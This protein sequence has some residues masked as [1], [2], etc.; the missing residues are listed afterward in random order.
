MYIIG[1]EADL[2]VNS[3]TYSFSLPI[4][5]EIEIHVSVLLTAVIAVLVYT[6]GLRGLGG[7]VI[8]GIE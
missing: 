1:R 8:G 5:V 2:G 4:L 7:L 3:P 6:K